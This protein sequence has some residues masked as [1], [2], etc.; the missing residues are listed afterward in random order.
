MR[1]H[2]QSC[3][4]G[5][6]PLARLVLGGWRLYLGEQA[7]EVPALARFRSYRELLE[8]AGDTRDPELVFLVRVVARHGRALPGLVGELRRRAVVHPGTAERVLSTAHRAKGL[9]WDRVR[10][11]EDFPGLNELDARDRE[12]APLLAPAERDQELQLLYVAATRARLG[13][14]PNRAVRGCLLA[15][16]EGPVAGAAARRRRA[17]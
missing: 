6:E 4:G 14:E 12:G 5:V 3:L 8:E 11:A 16:G 15:A 13:L 9:E 10:L 2:P 1:H 17:A 7:P